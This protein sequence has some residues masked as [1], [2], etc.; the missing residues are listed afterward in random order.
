MIIFNAFHN[1]PGNF[2]LILLR[3]IAVDK[4]EAQTDT[5]F[6]PEVEDKLEI[7][8]EIS[9]IKTGWSF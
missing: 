6:F 7:Q 2:I 3:I 1:F 4:I 5:E 8:L 9:V